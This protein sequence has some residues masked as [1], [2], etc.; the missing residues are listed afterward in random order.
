[1]AD[2]SYLGFLVIFSLGFVLGLVIVHGVTALSRWMEEPVARIHL[3]ELIHHVPPQITDPDV[4]W[5]IALSY[6]DFIRQRDKD[7]AL[8]PCPYCGKTRPIPAPLPELKP[9]PS[10]HA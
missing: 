4:L 1:M 5:N 9:H 8:G 2:L 6:Q 3:P 7:N 10:S